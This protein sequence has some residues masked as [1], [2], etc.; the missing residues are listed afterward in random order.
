[1]ADR[2]TQRPS[3]FR[4]PQAG[5]RFTEGFPGIQPGVVT[6]PEQEPPAFPWP[7]PAVCGVCLSGL[8]SLPDPARAGFVVP[9]GRRVFARA[10]RAVRRRILGAG[11]SAEGL[12]TNAASGS[13]WDLVTPQ[14][15]SAPHAFMARTRPPSFPSRQAAIPETAAVSFSGR[16]SFQGSPQGISLFTRTLYQ[17]M[18]TRMVTW[19]SKIRENQIFQDFFFPVAI[20]SVLAPPAR[21]SAD[22]SHTIVGYG[23]RPWHSKR[24]RLQW[25]SHRLFRQG[26]RGWGAAPPNRACG[27][28]GR[29]QIPSPSV[30][31]RLRQMKPSTARSIRPA[32]T[33]YTT[34][35]PA[36][37]VAGRE[38]ENRWFLMV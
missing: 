16:G 18:V 7:K 17:I 27:S 37:P 30:L 11:E 22:R 4:F 24:R 10:F 29:C 12:L 20:L 23:L 15:A 38:T 13:C 34:P 2:Q 32:P 33:A 8:T 21:S 19:A 14:G 25:F 3:H 5:E 31:L 1:M 9:I 35:V 36:P 26:L 6:A 28:A